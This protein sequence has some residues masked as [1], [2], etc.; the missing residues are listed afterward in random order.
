MLTLL[1]NRCSLSGQSTPTSNL[2]LMGHNFNPLYRIRHWGSA[3]EGHHYQFSVSNFRSTTSSCYCFTV[4]VQAKPRAPA[5]K[6]IRHYR[7]A[8]DWASK[9]HT[10]IQSGRK[11]KDRKAILFSRKI[12][13][14]YSF[15]RRRWKKNRGRRIKL[16]K[17]ISATLF[18]SRRLW[19]KTRSCKIRRV[20]FFITK[21]KIAHSFSKRLWKK[22]RDCIPLP[23]I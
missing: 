19:K 9:E 14:M 8:R 16:D 22:T 3:T 12:S 21:R 6:H 5:S 1:R 4:T 11:W 17:R 20:I 18:F 15:S 7:T 23:I 2:N 10:T 13:T